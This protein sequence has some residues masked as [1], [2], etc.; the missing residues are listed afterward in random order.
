MSLTTSSVEHRIGP[1]DTENYI[2]LFH[3]T[4]LEWIRLRS[5]T[6]TPMA[7]DLIGKKAR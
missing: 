4:F 5:A 1:D 6:S 2:P 3:N 7:N